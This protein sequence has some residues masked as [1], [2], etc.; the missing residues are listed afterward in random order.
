MRVINNHLAKALQGPVL[1]PTQ[2]PL[3]ILQFTA[4]Y[5]ATYCPEI[6]ATP[7][8]A[9]FGFDYPLGPLVGVTGSDPELTQGMRLSG[10]ISSQKYFIDSFRDALLAKAKYREIAAI[11]RG[12]ALP[13]YNTNDLVLLHLGDSNG[14]YS[15]KTRCHAGPFK[16]LRSVSSSHYMICGA[17]S[18][19][20]TVPTVKLI[21]YCPS[22]ADLLGHGNLAASAVGA[23]E[24][25]LLQYNVIVPLEPF[26]IE[27]H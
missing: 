4:V 1:L 15:T 24:A 25:R 2:W 20:V 3:W 6:S 7:H 11:L 5:N 19:P 27:E 16:V 21:T 9:R 10:I 22:L 8:F 18:I 23:A 14:A 12:S 17:D 13:H 26:L